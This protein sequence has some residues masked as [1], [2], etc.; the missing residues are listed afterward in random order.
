[1][2]FPAAE[3]PTGLRLLELGALGGVGVGVR[4][5]KDMESVHHCERLGHCGLQ[6]EKK[7]HLT[8]EGPKRQHFYKVI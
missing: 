3:Q 2:D 1:M 5:G 4:V 8:T 6:L 7:L